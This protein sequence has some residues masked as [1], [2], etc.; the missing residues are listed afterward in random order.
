MAQ[1]Q[2]P[3]L[4][5]VSLAYERHGTGEP[6]VLL[7]GLGHR[8]QAWDPVLPHVVA[9]REAVA[10][11]L[12][13]FGQSPDPDPAVPRD[14]PT[15]VAMFGSVFAALGLER[16]HVVGHSLGGLVAL[17]LGQAGL[18][19]SVTALAPAGFWS[20]AERRYAFAALHTV[21]RGSRILPEAML[22]TPA[23]AAP[24]TAVRGRAVQG[25]RSRCLPPAV[26]A[27]IVA[28]RDAAGFDSVLRAGRTRGLFTGDIPGIP[29]TIVWGSRDRLLPRWQSGRLQAMIPGARQI[30]LAGCGH[31]PFRR[32]PELVARV[33][34]EGTRADAPPA[35]FPLDAP[36]PG[37][38]S[39]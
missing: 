32:A 16:P 36:A 2:A 34:L 5:A 29:V 4:P 3:G 24:G 22:R 10:F 21:R 1:G 18:A 39:P 19:R 8:R 14:L 13:G 23:D 15:T 31:V 9:E 12:P 17:R 26:V 11:D 35:D 37:G 6:V 25:L 7:H 33:I 20:E 28:M 27:D 30:V 38:G